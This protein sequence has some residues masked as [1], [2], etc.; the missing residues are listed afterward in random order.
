VAADVTSAEAPATPAPRASRPHQLRL[1]LIY[2]GLAVV[3]ACAIAGVVVFAGRTIHPAP[4][5][6]SWKP[7]GGGQGATS[8]IAAHVGGMYHL[9]NGNQ[10]VDVISKEPYIPSSNGPVPIHYIA[11]RGTNGKPDQFYPTDPTNSVMYSLCGL[12]ASC[13]IASGKPSRERARL[14]QREIL[15][16]A[17][18]T[19]KYVRSMQN[20]VAF[21]PPPLGKQ[22]QYVVYLRASDVA[23]ELK[24]PLAMTL[25]PKAPLPQSIPLKEVQLIDQTTNPRVYS[26]GVA[27]AP[28]GD[29]LFVLKP[30]N[31]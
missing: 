10:L 5:W 28:Q 2:G 18:Y 20:V 23:T 11:V 25:N 21:M 16:L 22:P 30:F 6:S 19:F 15:E 17:L 24:K 9:P 8:E 29:L 13:A 12:G 4:A 7:K 27:Q 3:F 31:G 14:V 26:F 1:S